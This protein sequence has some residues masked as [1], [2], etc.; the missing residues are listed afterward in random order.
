MQY[1][2]DVARR[3]GK[4]TFMKR[5]I[6][7]MIC[8]LMGCYFSC[9]SALAREN[10]RV[11][12]SPVDLSDSW[13][14]YT[15]DID[16]FNYSMIILPENGRL[17]LDIQTIL[18]R[19]NYIRLY[20]CNMKTVTSESVYGNAPNPSVES[21]VFDLTAGTYYVVVE[22]TDGA[23]GS[24]RI[25]AKLECS[26]GCEEEPNDS[27]DF[28]V[29]YTLGTT[30]RGFLSSAGD[31]YYPT[32]DG[33]QDKQD[34]F[35]FTIPETGAYDISLSSVSTD[36]GMNI[37]LYDSTFH[38]IDSIYF[39]VSSAST[40]ETIRFDEGQYYAM[41]ESN[42][43]LA[44]DYLF[45][46]VEE[47]EIPTPW[48]SS[49]TEDISKNESG[50]APEPEMLEMS[51]Q[52]RD[53]ML[54]NVREAINMVGPEESYFWGTTDPSIAFIMNDNQ[55]VGLTPGT[56]EVVGIPSNGEAAIIYLVT[57]Q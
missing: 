38:M 8:C 33:T 49:V 39:G 5:W 19:S 2:T 35:C 1:E 43:T 54:L 36:D 40:T 3:I 4:E 56:T 6:I 13:Q 28:A 55:L 41:I 16:A 46:V 44:G 31:G 52:Y 37:N 14:D 23:V 30:I 17:V 27:F 20:D 50:S 21:F 29:P 45:S 12:C 22:S 10:Y 42:N 34:V 26:R 11:D 25:K 53:H 47:N 7:S 51:V 15:L 9:I 32:P 48:S 57:V 18:N 24:Y